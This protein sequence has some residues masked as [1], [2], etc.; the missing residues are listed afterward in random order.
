VVLHLT[1]DTLQIPADDGA[2]VTEDTGRGVHVI[3][4][5]AGT[6]LLSDDQ[7]I[8]AVAQNAMFG[9]SLWQNLFDAIS[10]YY[11]CFRDFTP[12]AEQFAQ[13]VAR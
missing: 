2:A 5:S 3:D 6:D 9:A 12:S 11:L 8:T 7:V 10:I 1:G 13:A 4:A